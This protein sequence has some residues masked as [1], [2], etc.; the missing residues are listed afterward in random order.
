MLHR[1]KVLILFALALIS[2]CSS[3]QKNDDPGITVPNVFVGPIR[4]R[5]PVAPPIK[6]NETPGSDRSARAVEAN[7]DQMECQPIDQ[8]IKKDK[9]K[10]ILQCFKSL[11]DPLKLNF[12]LLRHSEPEWV[13][14]VGED[15]PDC[16]VEEISFIPVPRE[17]FFLADHESVLTCI[18]SRIDIERDDSLD[19]VWLETDTEMSVT[20]ST[21]DFPRTENDTR[22]LI[23]AWALSPFFGKNNTLHG[24][25]VPRK[26]CQ[27]CFQDEKIFKSDTREFPRWP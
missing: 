21:E 7:T 13:L 11:K 25:S 14:Q 8:L 16:L 15:T 2:N 19:S 26:M 23:E 18:N 22:R 4:M 1:N 9:M 10:K 24:K 17:V 6:P 5:R 27:A 3:P 20:L 12:E